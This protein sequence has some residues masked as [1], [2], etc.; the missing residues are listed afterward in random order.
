[1]KRCVWNA[2]FV[3]TIFA[4]GSNAW[5]IPQPSVFPQTPIFII[6]APPGGV[7]YLTS[8]GFAADVNGD[9]TPDLIYTE[10]PGSGSSDAYLVAVIGQAGNQPSQTPTD[11]GACTPTLTAA[12]DVNGDKKADVVLTCSQGFMEVLIGNGDGT[13]QP[14]VTS[15]AP[16][17]VYSTMILADLNDDGHPDIAWPTLITGISGYAID[18]N[19]G[20]GHFG[21]PQTYSLPAQSNSSQMAV[22]DFNGDGKQD[23]VFSTGYLLGNGD[24]T[25]GSPVSLPSGI[26]SLA[27]GDWNNDGYEDLA[28][29]IGTQQPDSSTSYGLYVL[30]SSSSGFSTEPTLIANGYQDTLLQARVLPGSSNLDLIASLAGGGFA[31]FNGNGNGAFSGPLSYAN[32]GSFGIVP[33]A[34]ADLNGD[35]IPDLVGSTEAEFTAAYGNPDGTFQGSPMTVTGSNLA[36]TT[37]DIN[38]DGLMD[39]IV[40]DTTSTNAPQVYL[41]NGSGRFTPV[42]A[43]STASAGDRGGLL[44]SADFN[45]DG[46]PDLVS[47]FRGVGIYPSCGGSCPQ[48]AQLTSYLSNGNGS[49]T[50]VTQTT[51]AFQVVTGAV[52]GDFNG[53]GKQDL[54]LTYNDQFSDGGGAVFLAGKGDGTFA[55]PKAIGLLGNAP[56]AVA[57]ADLNNDQK[58]DLV[59]ADQSGT[60]ASLLGNGDGTFT[61]VSSPLPVSVTAMD[62][63]DV[64]GD[65]IPDLI[66]VNGASGGELEVLAGAG[67][68][69]FSATPSFTTALSGSPTTPAVGDLNGDGLLDIGVLY[70]SDMDSSYH[71]SA[72]LNQ[73]SWNF[74]AAANDYWTAP[75]NPSFSNTAPSLALVKAN[76]SAVSTGQKQY[77][78]ALIPTGLTIVTLLNQNNPAPVPMQT[79]AIALSASA[80]TA[81]QGGDLTFTASVTP[82]T[83]TGTVTFFDGST[84]LGTNALSSGTATMSTSSLATGS[85]SITASYSGDAMNAP[86]TSSATSVSITAPTYNVVAN[87]ASLTIAQG[88]TGSTTINVTPVGAY[89]GTVTLRCSGLPANSTC[90]FSPAMLSFTGS[91]QPAAQTTTLTIATNVSVT[92][93]SLREPGIGGTADLFFASLFLLPTA[94]LSGLRRKWRRIQLMLILILSCVG[95]SLS[96]CSSGNKMTS[97]VTPM[98]TSTI[99]ISTSGSGPSANLIVTVSQ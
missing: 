62:L 71:L 17:G 47:I 38:G 97:A 8:Q 63:A 76:N 60:V 44:I 6:Y 16:A 92:S 82:A 86:A 90:T 20:N 72:F 81:A 94:F 46:R 66:C 54:V 29:V 78:D 53:D 57:V 23:L 41:G 24:G 40:R 13:F 77:L 84:A 26:H 75:Q 74:S 56:T 18:L 27:L 5:A 88:S 79:T 45:G 11:L 32:L 51:T 12:G 98:G 28:A 91:G 70:S 87:P 64:N 9:G 93:A 43:G 73:G 99:S 3:F 96:G 10:V 58:L 50:Y 2:F 34:F 14:P 65:Q 59:V 39:V 1:M 85:H 55:D 69:T 35:G 67:N 33:G 31:V 15:S 83:A 30:T 4:I 80:A 19:T 7:A 37:A 49:L 21:I 42:A 61:P 48:P 22:G 36:T 89:N 68:G 52:R 95:L 25:F